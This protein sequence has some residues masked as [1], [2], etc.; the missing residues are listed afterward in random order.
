MTQQEIISSLYGQDCRIENKTALSGGDINRAFL[1]TLSNGEKLFVKENRGKAEDFFTAE[2]EGL[3]ALRKTKTL[4]VP[5]VLGCGKEEDGRAFLMLEAVEEGRTASDF[6]ESFGQGL[7]KLHEAETDSFVTGGKYGFL[8][9]NYIGATRQIN[10]GAEKWVDFYRESRLEIQFRM[11][12]NAFEEND[13][14][15]I[16][17]LLDHLENWIDEPPFPSL[18]HG[19]LWSGNFMS[20]RQGK[21]VLID[22]AVYVG[23]ADADL[24]MTELFGGF[25]GMF[26]SAYR[27]LSPERPGYGDR[28]DLYQLYHLLNHLNLFGGGYLS[29]VLRIVRQYQ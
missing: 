27:E 18:L 1:L 13:R 26:Y 19:D 8:I 22:P 21:A 4:P 10:T 25:S 7:A 11:A 6:W 20:D 9:P 16:G 5:E 29:S 17:G 28:R 3:K 23:D 24:A 15:R 2:A 12:W 14:K